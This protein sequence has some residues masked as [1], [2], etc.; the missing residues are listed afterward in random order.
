[1]KLFTYHLYQSRS[2]SPI[3]EHLREG[4]SRH[5]RKA[6]F[7]TLS[8][9]TEIIQKRHSHYFH[10]GCLGISKK[11]LIEMFSSRQYEAIAKGE[12]FFNKLFKRKHWGNSALKFSNAWEFTEVGQ[13][14]IDDAKEQISLYGVHYHLPLFTTHPF[15]NSEP[16]KG[17][18]IP[19]RCDL[20]LPSRMTSEALVKGDVRLMTALYPQY[21]DEDWL[22]QFYC[23]IDC[24]RLY[25]QGLGLQTMKKGLRNQFLSGHYSYDIE[26]AAPNI[27]YQ[28]YQKTNTRRMMELESFINDR[29][30]WRE[31]LSLDLS[32]PV[33]VIK[34]LMMPLFFGG[35]ALYPE[36]DSTKAVMSLGFDQSSAFKILNQ[37]R[38]HSRY[39]ALAD[40]VKELFDNI[41]TSSVP[42]AVK[43]RNERVAF[44]Y[45]NAEAKCQGAVTNHFGV[46]Q[47][48]LLIHDG[49]VMPAEHSPEEFEQIIMSKTG[50]EV[51]LEGEL[52]E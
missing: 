38:Y 6:Y 40:E 31:R 8:F 27:L 11:K 51:K 17:P 19:Q 26:C 44:L 47:F 10:K 22:R 18:M 35:N 41:D 23:Q 52:I 36:S 32:L 50:F 34:S 37:A 29:T 1:M 13:K 33:S 21:F 49:W 3:L 46:D 15:I 16:T 48:S 24:G 7:N 20:Y 45:R 4:K 43:G 39:R 5:Y 14:V 9:L 12:H 25:N 30:G 42:L 28:N 2:L